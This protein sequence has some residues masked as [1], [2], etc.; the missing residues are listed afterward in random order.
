M[1][2]LEIDIRQTLEKDNVTFAELSRIDGFRGDLEIQFGQGRYN[3]LAW[4][5][6]SEEAAQILQRL[7]AEGVFHFDHH[8]ASTFL[9]Y[10]IDGAQL[11]LPL[12]K[13][14]KRYAKPHWLPVTLVL[15]PAG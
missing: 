13:D 11:N 4:S 1:T 14:A 10:M 12:A 5:G 8:S 15:G 9:C 3:I 6:V 2:Q 7:E